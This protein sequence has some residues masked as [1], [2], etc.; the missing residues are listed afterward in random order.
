MSDA[1]VNNSIAMVSINWKSSP[2]RS[3]SNLLLGPVYRGRRFEARQ[4]MLTN[5][6]SCSY[7]AMGI[8]TFAINGKQRS[9]GIRKQTRDIIAGCNAL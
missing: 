7:M 9:S 3:I 6:W 1:R 8:L 5:R 2:I 4:Q